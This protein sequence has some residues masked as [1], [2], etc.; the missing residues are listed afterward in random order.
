MMTIFTIPLTV[1]GVLAITLRPRGDDW[2]DDDLRALAVN[3]VTVLVSLLESH[4]EQELGLEREATL[5]TSNRL[6][7]ISVPTPD[8]G[9]P[10]DFVQFARVVTEVFERLRSGQRVALHC[11]QS[12]GRSGL[13]AI[14][15]AL[16]TGLDLPGSIQAVSTARGIH[17]PETP[18]QLA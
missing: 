7:F 18:A 15:L 5:C 14:S 16:M 1:P 12:V 10:S 8:L 3:G 6:T 9:V 13:I 2:L 11:G 17:V 4:E